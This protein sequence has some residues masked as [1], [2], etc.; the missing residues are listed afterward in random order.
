MLA[1]R[2]EAM[3]QLSALSITPLKRI[4]LGREYGIVEWLRSGYIDLATQSDA[5]SLDEFSALGLETALLLSQK[6]RRL[7]RY[8]KL[9]GSIAPSIAVDKH[10]RQ[11]MD[12]AALD[13]LAQTPYLDEVDQ[14]LLA[15]SLGVPEWLYTAYGDLAKREEDITFAEAGRLGIETTRGL[16]HVR[17]YLRVQDSRNAVRSPNTWSVQSSIDTI[18]W[19]ELADVG[20]TGVAYTSVEKGKKK[21]NRMLSKNPV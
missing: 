10:F 20:R 5:L 13:G 6:V 14:I 21:K 8:L 19:K 18:F 4:L 1:L 7:Y 17:E 15:Q 16:C 2:T 11:L 3:G 12:G 9:G